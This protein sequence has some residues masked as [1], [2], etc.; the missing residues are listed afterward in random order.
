MHERSTSGAEPH[1]QIVCSSSRNPYPTHWSRRSRRSWRSTRSRRHLKVVG[2]DLLPLA[3]LVGRGEGRHQLGGRLRGRCLL[4]RQRSPPC[5]CPAV[6]PP[7]AG[8]RSAVPRPRLVRR[9]HGDGPAP[10]RSTARVARATGLTPAMRAPRV[11]SAVRGPRALVQ[12]GCRTATA[13]SAATA[14]TT[15]FRPSPACTIS[16]SPGDPTDPAP[17]SGCVI[18]GVSQ[19]P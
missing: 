5:R 19:H 8:R 14:S 3:C 12:R 11:S 18:T 6:R 2:V 4:V 16:P 10:A 13:A 15:R 17:A 9:R 7:S 1:C